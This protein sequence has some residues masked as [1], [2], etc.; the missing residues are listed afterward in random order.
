MQKTVCFSVRT[1]NVIRFW[2]VIVFRDCPMSGYYIPMCCEGRLVAIGATEISTFSLRIIGSYVNGLW[3]LCFV[4]GRLFCGNF[5]V[6]LHRGYC[7][8]F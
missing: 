1:S 7:S 5:V 2:L 3:R 8:D 6:D 4:V